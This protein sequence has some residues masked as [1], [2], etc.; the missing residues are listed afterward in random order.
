MNRLATHAATV[1]MALAAPALAQT[2]DFGNDSS[3]W[4]N[5]G[6]CD[7]PRFEGA[8][9]TQ[10]PLLEADIGHDATDCRAAFEDGKIALV[11]AD[12][13]HVTGAPTPLA[14]E[15]SAPVAAAAEELLFG[16]DTATW[17]NDGEC[18]DRRFRGDGM[19]DVL[20]WTNVG[21]DASDCRALFEAGS[22]YRWNYTEARAAT[23]CSAIDFGD[24]ASEYPKDGDCDDMRFEG[25][26]AASGI[27]PDAVGHDAT[28]C[29]AACDFNTVALRNY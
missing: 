9:L 16:T 13:S 29:S 20:I 11:E 15:S 28:D 6:E 23:Q 14:A 19:A 8:G 17:A 1:L 24:D 7:D 25:L 22:I 10:T 4:A 27:G 18:D 3:Q 21:Q 26:S 2:P 5:D 12:P